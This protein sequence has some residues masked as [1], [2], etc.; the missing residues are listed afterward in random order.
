MCDGKRPYAQDRTLTNGA[1]GK[2][3]RSEAP[4]ARCRDRLKAR[5]VVRSVVVCRL[6][7]KVCLFVRR[8]VVRLDHIVDCVQARE[9][10]PLP[11]R[12]PAV[13]MRS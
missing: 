1:T 11:A 6:Q 8:V 12:S 10:L 4:G 2:R 7:G 3:L 5:S 9:R 13:L